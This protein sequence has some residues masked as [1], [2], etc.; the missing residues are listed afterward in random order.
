MPSDSVLKCQKY[1]R[2]ILQVNLCIRWLSLG[3]L[4]IANGLRL[5]YLVRAVNKLPEADTSVLVTSQCAEGG[6][7]GMF[8]TPTICS[9]GICRRN[10]G[11]QGLDY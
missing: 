3:I 5:P 11:R 4:E 6:D 1:Y 9:P 10:S 7:K 2:Q 8:G